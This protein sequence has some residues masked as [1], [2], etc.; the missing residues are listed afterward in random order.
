MNPL[1]SIAANQKM[2]G[3]MNPLQML[4]Q[5]NQFK[6]QWTPR[7]AQQ[8]INHML[9]SGQINAEQLEQAKAMAQQMQSFFR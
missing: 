8:Q 1:A 3:G 2:A 9:Q 5:F 7:A 4:Q 6:Q